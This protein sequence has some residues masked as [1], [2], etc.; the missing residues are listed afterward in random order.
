MVRVVSLI[1]ICFSAIFV[2]FVTNTFY[3]VGSEGW[4]TGHVGQ[5]YDA[6]I[7]P[8]GGCQ[9][10]GLPHKHVQARLE[11]A[12]ELRNT[13]RYFIFLSRGTTHKPPPIHKGTGFPID[14]C[15]ASADYFYSMGE[16]RKERI[17]LECWSFDTIGNAVATLFFHILPA[18]MKKLLVI[19]NEFHIDRTKHIFEH[20]FSLPSNKIEADF[21]SV[22][23]RGLSD[24]ALSIRIG[25]EKKAISGW[26]E[27]MQSLKSFYDLHKF[28]MIEHHAYRYSGDK[29][30]F[31][32]VQD[33]QNIIP[34]KKG[35]GRVQL[36]SKLLLDTY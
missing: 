33:A 27:I 7:V 13:T 10:G 28:V 21:L 11:R 6:I 12:W 30:E 20:I 24:E 3:G 19:T 32:E 34:G 1:L 9:P 22:E 17:L 18:G 23:N 36:N 14:E 2:F 8:G 29:V 35:D 25:K 4:Y 16:V 26:K 5:R 31:D 15:K